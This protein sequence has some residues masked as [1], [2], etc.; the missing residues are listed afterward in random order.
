MKKLL[1]LIALLASSSFNSTSYA[2]KIKIPLS[3]YLKRHQRLPGY[4]LR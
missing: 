3:H 1:F 2:Q 4:R